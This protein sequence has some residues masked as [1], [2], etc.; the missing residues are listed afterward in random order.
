MSKNAED[1]QCPVCGYYCLGNGGNGC[2]DKPSMVE[3]KKSEDLRMD[4]YYYSFEAT[5]RIEIDR[6]NYYEMRNL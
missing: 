3:A 2:I 5:G 4:A 1:L 6:V